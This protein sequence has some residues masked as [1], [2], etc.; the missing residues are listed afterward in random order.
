MLMDASKAFDCLPHQLIIAKLKAY[1]MKKEGCIFIWS[2][3]SKHRQR[4]KLS[5]CVSERLERVQGVPHGS[6]ISPILFNI[7]MNDIYASIIRTSLYNLQMITPCLLQASPNKKSLS[8]Y[9]M[10][11]TK[12][13]IIP[14]ECTLMIPPTSPQ[15]TVT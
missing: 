8:V 6:I 1:G 11:E 7:F 10:M 5:G 14:S 2:Y 4:V 15:V 3:L 9:C 13:N 12:S